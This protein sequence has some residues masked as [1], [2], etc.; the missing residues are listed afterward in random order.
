MTWKFK[1][2]GTDPKGRVW[3]YRGRIDSP[4]EGDA[5]EAAIEVVRAAGD[6]PCSPVT[7]KRK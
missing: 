4:T 1:V 6:Q 5:R 3:T 2:Q 7:L